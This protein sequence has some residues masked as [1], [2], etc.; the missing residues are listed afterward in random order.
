MKIFFFSYPGGRLVRPPEIQ[1]IPPGS[2]S[3]PPLRGERGQSGDVWM[4]VFEFV[5]EK[6]VSFGLVYFF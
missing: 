4:L 6:D 1:Q 2:Q 5:W 3:T